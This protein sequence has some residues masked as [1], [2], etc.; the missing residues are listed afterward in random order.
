MLLKKHSD[1]APEHADDKAIK[2]YILCFVP[3]L[4]HSSFD[5]YSW[6]FL[7][8]IMYIKSSCPILHLKLGKVKLYVLF[9]SESLNRNLEDFS[10]LGTS[11]LVNINPGTCFSV[12]AVI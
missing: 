2:E 5:H 1:Q 3:W 7:C 11:S 12:F 6:S 9:V 10:G 8:L 4:I